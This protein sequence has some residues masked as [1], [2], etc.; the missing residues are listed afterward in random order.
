MADLERFVSTSGVDKAGNGTAAKPFRTIQKA[1]KDLFANLAAGQTGKIFVD[2]GLYEEV[3]VLTA[4]MQLLRKDSADQVAVDIVKELF[5]EQSPAVRIK[6]PSPASAP[7]QSSS[8]PTWPEVVKVNGNNVLIRG[9]R[10]EGDG[11]PQRALLIDHSENVTVQGCAIT[12]GHSKIAYRGKGTGTQADPFH[13]KVADE[14]EGA[15]LRIFE[16]KKVTVTNCVF[17]DNRTE[18]KFQQEV[19]DVDIDTLESSAKFKAAV[20]LGLVDKANV[21]KKLRQ[22]IPVRDG[23]GHVSCFNADEI[24][25]ENCIFQNGFAGGRGGALQFAHNSYGQCVSCLFLRNESGVDGGAVCL[26]DPDPNFF[27]RKLISFTSCKFKDNTSGDDA[28]AVYVTTNERASMKDCLFE[29]NKANSNGGALR[30]TFGAKVTLENCTFRNNQAN[31]DAATRVEKNQD[32]GGAIA[33]QDAS[34]EMTGGKVENNSVTGF[35]GGGIYFITAAYDEN[36]ERVAQLT[37][38]TTFESILKNGYGCTSVQL[39]ITGTV[40]ANNAASGE[41]CNKDACTLSPRAGFEQR[42]AGG[43]IYVLES[44]KDFKVPVTVLLA[45]VKFLENLAT[46]VEDKQ[47][48]DLVFRNIAKLVATGTAVVP[49]RFNKFAASFIDVRD[50]DVTG[51][52]AF[53]ALKAAGKIFE[54]GGSMKF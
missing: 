32:G 17:D 30:A 29:N 7:D 20:A 43:A 15:G 14:G 39:K 16:S 42:T 5:T 50:G 6:R 9:V 1:A 19:S 44:V 52:P 47:K 11:R 33:L 10:I 18:L 38:G 37:H 2:P 35:A 41:T 27:T 4:G 46:H 31:I 8:S 3:V 21:E 28:G 45:N 34:L 48:S 12:G 53:A 23:G 22:A 36:A 24:Q 40:F 51:S 25:F 54:S 26:S 49:H 13:S